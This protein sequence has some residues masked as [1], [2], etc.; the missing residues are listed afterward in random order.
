MNYRI[1]DRS[2]SRKLFSGRVDPPNFDGAKKRKI[3]EL[4]HWLYSEKFLKY[5]CC[6]YIV[7]LAYIGGV[8]VYGKYKINVH[9]LSEITLEHCYWHQEL[10]VGKRWIVGSTDGYTLLFKQHQRTVHGES[11]QALILAIDA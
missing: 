11:L 6:L 8:Y 3:V 7:V 9:E 1:V 5:H 4:N 10:G 2:C